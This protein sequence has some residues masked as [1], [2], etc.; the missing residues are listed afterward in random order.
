M[1]KP[2]LLYT[3]HGG[4]TIHS[5]ELTGGKTVFERYLG[6]YDGKCEFYNTY[7]GAR[8]AVSQGELREHYPL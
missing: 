7:D 5:Y 3:H 8:T 1:K 6:C 2:E 4:G